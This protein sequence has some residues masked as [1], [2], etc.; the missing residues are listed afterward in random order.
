MAVATI[1]HTK[2]VTRVGIPMNG[3]NV[4]DELNPGE[5]HHKCRLAWGQMKVQS[6]DIHKYWCDSEKIWFTAWNLNLKFRYSLFWI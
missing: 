3:C 4:N 2:P 6:F 1:K 5:N